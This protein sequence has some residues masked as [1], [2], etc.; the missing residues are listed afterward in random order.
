MITMLIWAIAVVIISVCI[1][2][3]IVHKIYKVLDKKYDER[4]GRLES[5]LRILEER[6]FKCEEEFYIHMQKYH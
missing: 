5:K 1:S 4:V 2:M 6:F 3:L